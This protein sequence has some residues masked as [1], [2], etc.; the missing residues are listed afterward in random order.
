MAVPHDSFFSSVLALPK[1]AIRKFAI[2][3]YAAIPF[4]SSTIMENASPSS[5]V[6]G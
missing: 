3:N 2:K 6:G 4:I 1:L 5:E